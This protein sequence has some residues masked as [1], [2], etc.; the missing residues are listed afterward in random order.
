MGAKRPALS[1]SGLRGTRAGVWGLGVEG[2]ANLR[3]LATLGAEPVLV[4]DRPAGPGPDGRPVLATAEG[5]LDALAG[6]EVVV[7]SP[8]ISRYRPE[9]AELT[10]RGIP[11]AGGLGLW[12]AEADRGRP[13]WPSRPPWWR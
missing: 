4:D 8:G 9:V 5:G 10:G 2:R 13:T 11:V 6:C 3:K 12:L 1:W 7:K